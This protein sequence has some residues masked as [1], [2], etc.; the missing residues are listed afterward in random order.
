MVSSLV[1]LAVAAAR[2]IFKEGKK[3]KLH[4]NVKLEAPADPELNLS[5]DIPEKYGKIGLESAR[6][7]QTIKEGIDKIREALSDRENNSR[8]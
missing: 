2:T 5:V 1:E 4:F 3:L 6:L 8:N 7:V